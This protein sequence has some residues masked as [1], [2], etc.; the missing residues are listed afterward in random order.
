L[1]AQILSEDALAA[2]VI[3][4]SRFQQFIKVMDVTEILEDQNSEGIA[5]LSLILQIL[6]RGKLGNLEES[7][8]GI[9]VCKS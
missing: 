1:Q 9:A 4:L 8:V 3:T 5:S 2:I 7:E 6:E